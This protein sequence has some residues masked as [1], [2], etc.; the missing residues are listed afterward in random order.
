MTI[1]DLITQLTMA[2][3]VLGEVPIFAAPDAVAEPFDVRGIA[4][5]DGDVLV[6][7]GVTVQE[8]M[9]Q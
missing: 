8:A 3:E 7:L 2:R 4:D 9:Q 1:S 6:L 5:I